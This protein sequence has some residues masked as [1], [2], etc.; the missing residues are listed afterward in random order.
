MQ[1][2]S[3]KIEDLLDE[4][5]RVIVGQD[6]LKRDII[7]AL[8]S[9]GHI[10][11]EGVPGLAKTRTVSSFSQALSLDFQRI[12]FTPDLLPSDLIGARIY[13]PEAKIFEVK[14]G[15]IFANFILADEINRAPSK[16]QSALL[17]SMQEKQVTIG[18]ETFKL[19]NPFMVLAT[20]NPLE[21]E[22]TF[23][24][25]EAQLD[26]FLLKTLVDYP[27]AG[28]E[29]E[30][31]MKS[32]AI[33]K[34]K[35]SKIIGKKEI[36]QLRSVVENI[37]VSESIY[38]YICRIIFASRNTNKYPEIMY[39]GSPRATIALL[40]ASK[41][42]AGIQGRDFVLPE[43]IKEMAHA[44]LRHRIIMSYQAMAEDISSDNIIERILADVKV[45]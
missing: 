18:D 39:G 19:D 33:D 26:R 1:D 37:E 20:Q 38:E 43:D 28:E 15:P 8:L 6:D 24:L 12:Q 14:K 25:P 9:G 32:G 13:D 40:A 27:S 2:F 31:L 44:V 21:Q 34:Q 35:I 16:V 30:I 11:L 23:H 5:G 17:E 4:V 29:K 45:G 10:L 41:A 3:K 42:L 7:I 36:K 22:G